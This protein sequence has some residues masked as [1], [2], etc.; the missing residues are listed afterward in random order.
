MSFQNTVS[1]IDETGW[2]II[3]LAAVVLIYEAIQWAENF[4]KNPGGAGAA[5]G[6]A[7]GAFVAGAVTSAATAVG[8][9]APDPT[10]TTGNPNSVGDTSQSAY[11]GNG[12]FGWI[13]NITN[14][15]TAG[16]PQSIGNE[17]G[18]SDFDSWSNLWNA[19]TGNTTT[20]ADPADSGN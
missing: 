5:A 18:S 14:Q 17:I 16:I 4:G 3:G 20:T 10:D 7:V 13:G 12:F 8:L 9:G 19:F 2:V 15:L 6:G 1:E 11:A